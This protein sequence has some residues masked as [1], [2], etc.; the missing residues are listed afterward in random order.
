MILISWVIYPG[1]AQ[2]PESGPMGPRAHAAA[3]AWI[4]HAADLDDFLER[5]FYE[6]GARVLLLQEFVQGARKL[7]RRAQA[8][9]LGCRESAGSQELQ[10]VGQ[11]EATI[12]RTQSCASHDTPNSAHMV[13][14]Y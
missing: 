8:R 10:V 4:H 9:W 11:D 14:R 1:P 12:C 2:G 7:P 3:S 6:S 13:Q 5:I